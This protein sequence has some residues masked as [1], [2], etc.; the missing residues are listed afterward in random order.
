MNLY[1]IGKGH[2]GSKYFIVAESYADAEKL[3]R[4][5]YN[6]I[7]DSINYIS[8]YLLVQEEPKWNYMIGKLES[9]KTAGKQK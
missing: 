5:K 8:C 9:K 3:W 4:D 1:E 7:P 2:S 6:T